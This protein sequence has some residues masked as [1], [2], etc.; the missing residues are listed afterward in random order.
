MEIGP[1]HLS[2]GLFIEERA[3]ARYHDDWERNAA[4]LESERKVMRLI[5][6]AVAK[7]A[8]CLV[9]PALGQRPAHA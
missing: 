8:R 7:I 9:M 1:A 4:V 5:R 3:R 2:L 6:A